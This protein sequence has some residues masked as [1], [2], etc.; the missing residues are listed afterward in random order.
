MT[1][2]QMPVSDSPWPGFQAA[3][4]LTFD[5]GVPSH[6]QHAV[7]LLNKYGLRGTFYINPEDGYRERFA[8]WKEV[9]LAGHEI[10][11]HT[12]GH[13]CSA[14]YAFTRQLCRHALEEMTLVDIEADILEADRR[15][16][17]LFPE[18][19]TASFAYPCY[20]SFVGR[21]ANRQSYVP[22]V[23][24]HCVAGRASGSR[25]NDPRYC[26]LA[27]LWSIPCEYMTAPALIGLA[28]QAAALGHW[29]ILTFHGV[30]DGHLHVAYRD[31]EELCSFLSRQSQ[32]IYVAPVADVAGI[33]APWQQ[34][35]SALS[36]TGN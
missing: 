34:S 23:A 36:K 7:P 35:Q 9:A 25:P 15:I 17:E 27:H 20:E 19:R 5:D 30:N 29:L 13:P 18:Q 2:T 12:V 22:V 26:D 33:T 1:S 14:N 3:V 31:L 24:R 16:R 10:G 28:E 6:L 32:R 21:G 8:S 4:S 11:N